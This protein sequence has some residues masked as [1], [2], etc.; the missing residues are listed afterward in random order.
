MLGLSKRAL[1]VISD[2]RHDVYL[3][4]YRLGAHNGL[5]LVRAGFTGRPTAPVIIL[6]SQT[7]YEID[8]EATNLGV[9]DFLLKQ[10]LNPLSLERSIRYAISHHRAM[11]ELAQ[12][13]ERYAL[14]ARAV[15]DGIW[16]WD[17]EFQHGFLLAPMA[18][19]PRSAGVRAR[20]SRPTPGSSWSTRTTC[21]GFKK[22]SLPI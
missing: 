5:D 21:R 16:D 3:I 19:P 18:R 6:T 2:E 22:R 4:D 20:T 17:L 7:D 11:R 14:A 15:N 1:S 10:E 13:Q 12:S 9:T 8:L